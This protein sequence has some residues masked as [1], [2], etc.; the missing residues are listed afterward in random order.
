VRATFTGFSALPPPAQARSWRDV[1]DVS[2]FGTRDS[3]LARAQSHYRAL[4][5][6]HHPDR[7]GDPARMAEINAAWRSAQAHLS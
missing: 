4:A 1:L 2:D 3:Q 7:G 5:A 6:Q